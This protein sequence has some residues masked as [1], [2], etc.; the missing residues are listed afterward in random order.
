MEQGGGEDESQPPVESSS[1]DLDPILNDSSSSSDPFVN[2]DVFE[3]GVDDRQ[4]QNGEGVSKDDDEDNWED[5]TEVDTQATMATRVKR[6]E[7][8]LAVSCLAG[9]VVNQFITAGGLR[10]LT[11]EA[12]PGHPL[13]TNVSYLDV[14]DGELST[15]YDEFLKHEITV[16]LYYAPWDATSRESLQVLDEV[17][18]EFQ[19]VRFVA[20]NCWQNSACFKYYQFKFY[21]S[22][23]VYVRGQG[24]IQY[25][26]YSALAKDYFITFLHNVINP[27]TVVSSDYEWYTMRSRHFAVVTVPQMYYRFGYSL[28]LESLRKDP[29]Q[30]VGFAVLAK[31]G[32]DTVRLHLWNETLTYDE[33]NNPTVA[34]VSKW[35]YAKFHEPTG[36]LMNSGYKS[37]Q[38]SKLVNST[39][40]FI[41]VRTHPN[42]SLNLNLHMMALQ[43]YS[44][45]DTYE[46]HSKQ[47]LLSLLVGS[48]DR[49]INCKRMPY[50]FECTSTSMKCNTKSPVDISFM[51]NW[52]IPVSITCQRLESLYLRHLEIKRIC[53]THRTQPDGA[54]H[55]KGLLWGLGCGKEHLFKFLTLDGALYD[56]L[57]PLEA[58]A[59]IYDAEDDI[60]YLLPQSQFTVRGIEFF[61]ARYAV[62]LREKLQKSMSVV[63]HDLFHDQPEK[64]VPPSEEV[65]GSLTGSSRSKSGQHI[66]PAESAFRDTVIFFYTNWCGFCKSVAANFHRVAH[67]F[68]AAPISFRTVDAEGSR[69]EDIRYSPDSYPQVVFFPG[70]SSDTIRY[71]GNWRPQCLTRF[72]LK[73]CS[74]KVLQSL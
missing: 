16:T 15:V 49:S 21:P 45:Q 64:F 9:A 51:S 2:Q 39:K 41:V 31:G 33:S 29:R 69:F 74:D 70:N 59:I 46:A 34:S 47:V 1:E 6:I 73:H 68:K 7:I 23:S 63:R 11:R 20:I 4:N 28:A 55:P 19:D 50:P 62:K 58:P 37:N 53:Q 32:G 14:Y 56:Q 48:E 18:K 60:K 42:S 54:K 72:I 10:R 65:V 13:L 26:I 71:S 27:I 25:P 44:C 38:I 52:A 57:Y 36:Y 24:S 61:V 30:R 66:V 17:A 40:A 8:L 43:F 35:V 5:V 22:V 67:F 12:P 3:S